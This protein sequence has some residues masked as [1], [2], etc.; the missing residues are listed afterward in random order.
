MINPSK[1]STEESNKGN[2]V[3]GFSEDSVIPDKAHKPK[4]KVILESR[5]HKLLNTMLSL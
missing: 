2:S 1:S 3:K 4:T 5:F